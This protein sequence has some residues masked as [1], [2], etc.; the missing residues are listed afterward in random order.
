VIVRGLVVAALALTSLVGCGG[1]DGDPPGLGPA[2]VHR[3]PGC[4]RLDH[5]PCDVSTANCRE[6][7]MAVAACVRG[8]EPAPVPPVSVMTESAYASYLNALLAEE[9][10]PPVPNHYE[11]ALVLLK[12]ATPGALS[13]PRVV[14]EQAKFVGA[15]YRHDSK[16]IVLVEHAE[17]LDATEGSILF[18]H[19]LIHALQDRDVD[20]AAFW[21]EHATSV[22]A[23][24]AVRS[25]VEGEARLHESRYA[26]AALGLDPA[27]VDWAKHF[28]SAIQ[29]NAEELRLEESPYGPGYLTFPYFWGARYA[30]TAYR[31]GGFDG[32]LARFASPS[33]TSRA[34]MASVETPLPDEPAPPEISAPTLP[35]EWTPFTEVTLGA[36]GVYL[37]TEQTTDSTNW[38]S[39]TALAWRNDRLFVFESTTGGT[40]VVWH[41]ELATETDALD[42]AERVGT[43][44]ATRRSGTRVTI[45]V[46]NVGFVFP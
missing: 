21:E 42:F 27:G 39:S 20:L 28:D 36:F 41:L 25:V 29:R 32:V 30:Y 1:D 44:L 8:G 6:R 26:A 14:S 11:V 17:K 38:P 19:E 12:L 13:R 24:L 31:A 22:D 3:V 18:V 2:T 10:P 43:T 45:N 23:M 16:D 46:S 5:R 33:L 7:L 34:V 37:L 4:E 40:A 9:E 15:F 35:P